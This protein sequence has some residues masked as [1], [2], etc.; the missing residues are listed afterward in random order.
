VTNDTNQQVFQHR[1]TLLLATHQRWAADPNGH[2]LERFASVAV[3]VDWVS[4]RPTS[5]Q[6]SA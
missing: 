2:E 3:G 5:P 6:G 1:A 4:V